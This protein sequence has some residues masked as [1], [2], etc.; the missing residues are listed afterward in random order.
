MTKS[1]RLT[2]YERG[3]IERAEAWE[4]AH[5]MQTGHAHLRERELRDFIRNHKREPR[6]NAARASRRREVAVA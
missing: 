2:D 4:Y 1:N 6:R 5:L 3:V